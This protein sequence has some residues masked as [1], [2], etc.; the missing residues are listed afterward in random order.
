MQKVGKLDTKL[1]GQS[2]Q[3]VSSSAQITEM[4][5]VQDHTKRNNTTRK[6]EVEASVQ[7]LASRAASR[8]KAVAAE[9]ITPPNSAYQFEAISPS[10]LPQ[11][12]KNALTV[13][14]LLDIIKCA[15]TFVVEEMDLAVNYLENLTGVPRFDTLIMFLSSSDNADL[16]KIWDEVFDNEATPVEY[17]EKLDNLHTKYCPSDDKAQQVSTLPSSTS[18]TVNSSC[19]NLKCSNDPFESQIVSWT[20]FL[21]IYRDVKSTLQLLLHSCWT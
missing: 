18:C 1:N 15:A 3:P 10:A 8:V 5:A 7:E 16:V 11:I 13:P 6:Q 20:T 14:I 2:V 17:A 4:T 12:F 21:S 9:K 19:K